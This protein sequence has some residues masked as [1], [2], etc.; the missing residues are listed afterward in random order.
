MKFTGLGCTSSCWGVILFKRVYTLKS[1]IIQQKRN[2]VT[3]SNKS[4]SVFLERHGF[5]F[6]WN[7]TLTY[8]FITFTINQ[9]DCTARSQSYE[10]HLTHLTP[11]V[12]Y[13]RVR[14]VCLFSLKKWCDDRTRYNIAD[15]TFKKRSVI[16]LFCTKG[17]QWWSN[18]FL[19]KPYLYFPPVEVSDMQQH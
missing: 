12:G 6:Y 11:W 5:S 9:L 3:D 2:S 8:N 13:E 19:N 15:W 10:L 18:P 14:S 1:C 17:M 7:P 4:M 16:I